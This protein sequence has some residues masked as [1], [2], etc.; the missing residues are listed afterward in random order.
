MVSFSSNSVAIYGKIN[1]R[2]VFSGSARN[3][4]HVLNVWNSSFWGP[5]VNSEYYIGWLDIWGQ[6]HAHVSTVAAAKTLEE[7]LKMKGNVNMYMF[8]G[9]TNFGFTSG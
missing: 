3:G 8:F 2:L 9:G 4:Y 5:Y 6:K 7:T 1:R